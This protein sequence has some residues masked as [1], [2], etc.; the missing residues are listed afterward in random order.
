MYIRIFGP[1]KIEDHTIYIVRRI[2]ICQ[3]AITIIRQ[4]SKNRKNALN[5]IK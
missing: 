5:Q 1:I 2:W 4:L 3:K